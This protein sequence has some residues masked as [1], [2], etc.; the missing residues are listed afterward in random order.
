MTSALSPCVKICVVDPLGGFC[1]GCGRTIAEISLW[2]EMAQSHRLA[3]MAELPGRMMAARSRAA[4]GGRVRARG[5]VRALAPLALLAAALTALWFAPPQAPL[6]GLSHGDFARGAFG[7]S[8]ALWLMLSGFA[9]A[10]PTGAARV[11]AGAAFWALTG[12]ALVAVYAYRFEFSEIADRVMESSVPRSRGW[13]PAARSSSAVAWAASSSCPAKSTAGAVAFVFDTGASSVV[14]TAED[15]AAAGVAVAAD[16]FFVDVTTANGASH[17]GADAAR[18]GR[19]RRHC[20]A[21]RPRACCAAGALQ[22]SLLGMTF[23]E[24]LRS[25]AVEGGKLVFRGK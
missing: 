8:L 23:L 20:R 21:R 24:R 17:R 14:L 18:L 22:Q 10:G 6:L 2:P 19:G 9:R 16:D 1:I 4:R 7:V 5:R 25:F 11:L 13:G 12:L 3:V 15:A